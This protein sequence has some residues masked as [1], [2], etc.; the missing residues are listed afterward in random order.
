MAR[1]ILLNV[2]LLAAVS[3]SIG[4][5]YPSENEKAIDDG[6][7]AAYDESIGKMAAY[8]VSDG[9]MATYDDSLNGKIEE[10]EGNMAT[11]EESDGK[12]ATYDG[13]TAEINQAG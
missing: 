7:M 1:I 11:F 6:K 13:L 4:F 3:T 10:S 2:I 9:K 8:D 5:P 12:I